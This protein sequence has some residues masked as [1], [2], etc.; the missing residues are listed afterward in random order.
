MPTLPLTPSP[1][2]QRDSSIQ[3][4]L[5]EEDKVV[6]VRVVGRGSFLN[7]M[8]LQ[9]LATRLQA[10]KNGTPRFIVDLSACPTMD[11]TFMGALA[12]ITSLQMEAGHG[13]L[14]VCNAND[15]NV[16]LLTTLG[17]V[18][19]LDLRRPLPELDKAASEARFE[20]CER[21]KH[22]KLEQIVHMLSNHEKLVDLGSGNEVRF[23]DVVKALRK[24]LD[25]EKK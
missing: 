1:E 5:L 17:L 4:A 2:P 22:T 11:S 9:Q 19:I 24:S 20:A 18:N 23:N 6:V 7:S 21:T 3:Y 10:D 25:D 13:R 14:V 15:Q 16:K 12:Q 8:P